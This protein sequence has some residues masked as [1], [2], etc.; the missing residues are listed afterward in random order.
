[1]V[2]FSPVG[3]G[4]FSGLLQEAETFDERDFRH[5]SPRF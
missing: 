3:G 2:A 1:M 4:Y 5:G